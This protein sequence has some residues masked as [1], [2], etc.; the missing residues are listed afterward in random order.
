M[1]NPREIPG[2]A[3][4]ALIPVVPL[5]VIAL[6]YFCRVDLSLRK[7]AAASTSSLL[8]IFMVVSAP[9]I[10]FLTDRHSATQNVLGTV[11]VLGLPL[12]ALLAT[13]F[14]LFY[15]RTWMNLL[16]IPNLLFGTV[17]LFVTAMGPLG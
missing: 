15:V 14:T 9:F 13:V 10:A 4:A 7:R 1:F 3:E 17:A 12:L 5:S 16:Q 8:F 11:C 6:C 2:L